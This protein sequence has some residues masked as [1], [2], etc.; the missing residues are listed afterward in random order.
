MGLFS[1]VKNAG[2]KLF[3]KKKE[4]AT[5][6]SQYDLNMAKAVE[7]INAVQSYEIDIQDLSITVDGD[8]AIISGSACC[9][10][11]R[12]KAILIV[13]NVTGIGEVEDS[14]T[15][16]QTDAAEFHTVVSGDSLSKIAKTYYG[17]AMKYPVIFEANKPMLK[18]PDLIY[19]GQVLRIPAL[20]A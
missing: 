6:Q 12:E 13:G 16:D 9:Q 14:I 1:F 5:E 15:V 11:D 20:E 4:E 8:K 10:E 7:L 17:N 18:S 2:A 19:P 3:G